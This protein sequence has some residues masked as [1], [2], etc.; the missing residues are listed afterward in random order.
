M[1]VTVV[2]APRIRELSQRQMEFILARNHVGRVAFLRGGRV[3]LQPVHYVFTNS[4][5]YGRIGFG[6]KYRTWVD[7]ADVVF[8]VDEPD[9]LCDW[10]SVIV[11]GVVAL[12]ASRGNFEVVAEHDHAVAALRG[13]SGST[14]TDRDPTPHRTAIFRITPTHYSGREAVAR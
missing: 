10:R 14:F 5:I 3:E 4:V 13:F 7:G 9:A 11:R 8:E 1:P 12:V 6:V 2:R